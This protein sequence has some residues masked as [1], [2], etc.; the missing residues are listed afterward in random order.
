MR[1]MCAAVEAVM[2]IS[3]FQT[4]IVV[5]LFVTIFIVHLLFLLKCVNMYLLFL[6]ME[7]ALSNLTTFNSARS[8][9]NPQFSYGLALVNCV[10]FRNVTSAVGEKFLY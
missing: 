7:E 8:L 3:S 2:Q 4:A 5:C 10:V 1:A 6:T 9:S